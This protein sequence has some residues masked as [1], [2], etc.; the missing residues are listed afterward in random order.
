[1]TSPA[2]SDAPRVLVVDDENG[3][4]SLV[5]FALRHAGFEAVGAADGREALRLFRERPAA[6][7][8]CDLFMPE[9][10]GLQLIPDLLAEFGPVPVVAISGGGFDGHLDVLAVAERLGARSAIRKPFGPAAVVSAVR[11]ALA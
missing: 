4:R 7:V 11:A 10:N 5:L 6:V 3:V 1:V 2:P 9:V 8:V